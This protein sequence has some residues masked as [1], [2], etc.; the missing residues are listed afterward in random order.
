MKIESLVS[1]METSFEAI[2]LLYLIKSSMSISADES[3]FQ[4]HHSEKEAFESFLSTQIPPSA[5]LKT[6]V[7]GYLNFKE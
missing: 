7:F 2:S 3:L 6:K 1:D 5:S 4:I